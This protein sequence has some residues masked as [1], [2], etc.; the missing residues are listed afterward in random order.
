MSLAFFHPYSFSS[1]EYAIKSR[2]ITTNNETFEKQLNLLLI[3]TNETLQP[4]GIWWV[5]IVPNNPITLIS[6]YPNANL[7]TGEWINEFQLT[8]NELNEKKVSPDFINKINDQDIPWDGYLVLEPAALEILIN[9]VEGLKINGVDM[10]GKMVISQLSALNPGSLQGRAFQ[11]DVW[12][13]LCQKAIFAGSVS[14]YQ[15][16]EP[17]LSKYIILSSEF[18]LSVVDFQ[19]MLST[20]NLNQC[21][22]NLLK[23]NHSTNFPSTIMNNINLRRSDGN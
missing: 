8:D 17:E 10:D 2:T 11:S 12:L 19:A 22:V 16:V 18:P 23:S 20:A 6:L 13:K 7:D 4:I 3:Q 15:L 5:A 14:L 9:S 21:E 1:P